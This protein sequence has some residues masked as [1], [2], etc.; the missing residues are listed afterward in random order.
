ML[1]SAP[2]GWPTAATR[3][4]CCTLSNR[5]NSPKGLSPGRFDDKEGEIHV[6]RTWQCGQV[7]QGLLARSESYGASIL[8]RLEAENEEPTLNSDHMAV[9]E[10]QMAIPATGND[11]AS[12]D[13]L[14]GLDFDHAVGRGRKKSP[15]ARLDEWTWRR[16]QCRWRQPT[17]KPP[18]GKPRFA[19]S[20]GFGSGRSRP[21]LPP[22]PNV[23][24]RSVESAQ[25]ARSPSMRTA[26]VDGPSTQPMLPG[27]VMNGA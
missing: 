16:R 22:T 23:E 19:L 5:R 27:P 7:S 8:E 24:D 13:R 15:Q 9:R 25:E 14:G 17:N 11:K 3:S 21:A 12:P 6:L 4:P 26:V 20:A 1:K 2:S 10:Y 18:K